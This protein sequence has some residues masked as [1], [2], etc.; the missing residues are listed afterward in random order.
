MG[1]VWHWNGESWKIIE[2]TN[3]EGIVVVGVWKNNLETL[4]IA[5]DGRMTFIYHG[6]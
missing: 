4:I 3:N 1:M 6:K 5:M 2:L